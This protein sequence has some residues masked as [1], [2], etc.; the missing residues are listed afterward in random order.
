MHVAHGLAQGAVTGF[1]S[2]S[3]LTGSTLASSLKSLEGT[4]SCDTFPAFWE[5][6]WMCEDYIHASWK[7]NV[8]QRSSSSLHLNVQTQE[9]PS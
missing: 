3:C 4:A 5:L 2:Q 1:K 9:I 8:S 6:A 7:V